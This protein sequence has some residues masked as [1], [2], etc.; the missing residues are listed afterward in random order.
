MSKLLNIEKTIDKEIRP[1]ERKIVYNIN[2]KDETPIKTVLFRDVYKSFAEKYGVNNLM[3]RAVNNTGVFTYKGFKD[4]DMNLDDMDDY[5]ENRVKST[6][7]F[8]YWYS[9]EITI[10]KK[11]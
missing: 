1:K 2:R 6:K 9:L 5:Y 8:D 7:E 3:V 11:T 4:M 10:L